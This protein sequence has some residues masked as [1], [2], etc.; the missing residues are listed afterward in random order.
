MKN[1]IGLILCG[2]GVALLTTSDAMINISAS[3][4]L[5]STEESQQSA[6]LVA[7]GIS[8][9]LIAIGGV[10][11]MIN[12]SVALYGAWTVVIIA[13]L[14]SA[15]LTIQ[16]VSVDYATNER[17]K[18]VQTFRRDA[19]ESKGYDLQ[20]EKSALLRKMEECER[21][22]YYVPC[23]STENRIRDINEKL[24]KLNDDSVASK[25]AES[26]NV[27]DAVENIAGV[28]SASIQKLIIFSRA[29]CVPILIAILSF[30]FW[31]YWELIVKDLTKRAS[32]LRAQFMS[33]NNPKKKVMASKVVSTPVS[34]IVSAVPNGPNSTERVIADN[35]ESTVVL[36]REEGEKPLKSMPPNRSGTKSNKY[37]IKMRTAIL[38]R[39]VPDLKYSTIVNKCG[40]SQS[41]AKEVLNELAKEGHIVKSGRSWTWAKM[42]A[43]G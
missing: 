41:T 7:I 34:T 12:D 1:L 38:N 33:G 9:S 10:L 36:D 40:G 6:K 15:G 30:G 25:L 13:A 35:R 16:G 29:F 27:S 42:E 43:Q 4:I 32:D 11:T 24:M 14:F 8:I 28:S 22:R 18:S 5:G 20:I 2:A 19:N 3:Y 23:R 17:G 39:S 37:R 31:S 21:D 26:V